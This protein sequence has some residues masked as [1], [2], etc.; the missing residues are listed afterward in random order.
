MMRLV[1]IAALFGATYVTA[2]YVDGRPQDRLTAPLSSF[3]TNVSGWQMTGEM[4]LS[5]RVF[6]KLL[7]SEYVSRRYTSRDLEAGLLVAYYRQQRA[8]EAIHS[9]LNCLP[10]DGWEI[11]DHNTMTVHYQHGAVPINVY[12]IQ[13][14]GRRMLA[15]YWYQTK[16]HIIAGELEGKVMLL[17]DSLFHG[18]TS[19]SIVRIIVPERDDAVSR[20]GTF[21]GA[22]M[23]EVA[24]CF[25]D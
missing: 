16:G 22:V 9:P 24:R 11:S 8:G 19:G 14:S 10:G 5:D 3:S 6:G 21:A 18:R 1:V 17:A 23:D 13:K 7:P 25:G 4:P 2:R 15:L 20:T 12:R